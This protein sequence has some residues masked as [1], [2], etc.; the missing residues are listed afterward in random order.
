[1]AAVTSRA[2]RTYRFTTRATRSGTGVVLR[3]VRDVV[4]GLALPNIE[5]PDDLL[6]PERVIMEAPERW[7]LQP[8]PAGFGWRQRNWYPRSASAGRASAF[9]RAGNRDT[10]GADGTAVPQPRRAR[11][12]A[13]TADIRGAV[14]QRRALTA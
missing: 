5:D 2:S 11:Q 1:M 8:L 3:N 9:S 13:S 4:D 6:I 10:R 14:Q 12:A 7:P